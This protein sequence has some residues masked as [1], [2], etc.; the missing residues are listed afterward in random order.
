MTYRVDLAFRVEESLANLPGK[1]QQE[2]FETIA[3]AL[4][5]PDSWPPPGGR[6]GAFYW[7]PRSWVAFAAYLDG[8]EVYDM[9]WAG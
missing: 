6:H 2:I 4:V 5:R 9:G 3:A 8:I 7:G 1:G